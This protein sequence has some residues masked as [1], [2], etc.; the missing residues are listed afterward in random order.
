MLSP[1]IGFILLSHTQVDFKHGSF[2][3]SIRG[4]DTLY[5]IGKAFFEGAGDGNKS[6]I[7]ALVTGKFCVPHGVFLIMTLTQYFQNDFSEFVLWWLSSGSCICWEACENIWGKCK[8]RYRAYG[9]NDSECLGGRGHI[10]HLP[11][12]HQAWC[13][14]LYIS[15]SYY[16]VTERICFKGVSLWLIYI[17]EFAVVRNR[18]IEK[19]YNLKKLLSFLICNYGWHTQLGMGKRQYMMW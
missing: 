16:I 19:T 6:S 13:T 14:D 3:F 12:S 8:D 17:S 4:C 11:L 10:I 7:L 15:G 5:F 9:K 18:S 2:T 1:R